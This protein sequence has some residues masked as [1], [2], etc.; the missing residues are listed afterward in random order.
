M[1]RVALFVVLLG[2][3]VKNSSI[4]TLRFFLDAAWQLPLVAIMLIF[5]AAGTAVGIA[6]GFTSFLRQR[7]EIARLR[8]EVEQA[9][10][11][12]EQ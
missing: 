7:R 6:A 11:A 5:F 1:L 9:G 2:F 3:A 12:P 4:V 8:R 10:A